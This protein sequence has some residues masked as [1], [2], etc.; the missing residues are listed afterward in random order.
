MEALTLAAFMTAQGG[1][2]YF[3]K[4]AQQDHI[5]GL[6]DSVLFVALNSVFQFVF[7]LVLP[8]YAP[9]S[10]T[11]DAWT[12]GGAFSLLYA[13]GA[14]LL[15]MALGLGP[16]SLTHM[17][18]NLRVFIPVAAGVLLWHEPFRWTAGAGIALFVA[19]MLLVNRPSARQRERLSLKWL[20]LSI[21]SGVAYG[22]AICLTK[23]YGMRQGSASSREYLLAY[24]A[25]L[26]FLAIPYLATRRK[27]LNIGLLRERRFVRAAALT[28]LAQDVMNLIFMLYINRFSAAVYF[29]MTSALAI[30]AATVVGRVF[31]REHIGARGYAGIMLAILSVVLLNL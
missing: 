16:L 13:V 26:V 21:A 9:L 2:Y 27:S 10:F 14:V 4:R 23:A 6:Y 18:T 24:N 1:Y 22:A 12:L 28:A 31:F 30:L 8:P 19:A 20:L 11:A 5:R 17:I 29:P 15:F 7:L 3:L 25:M